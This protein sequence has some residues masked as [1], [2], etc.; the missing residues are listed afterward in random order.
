MKKSCTYPG[1]GSLGTNVGKSFPRSFF[2]TKGKTLTV[3]VLLRE[4]HLKAFLR[5]LACVFGTGFVL[6]YAYVSALRCN[7]ERPPAN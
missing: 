5:Q 6:Q 3:F 2:T 1:A 7:S 4:A